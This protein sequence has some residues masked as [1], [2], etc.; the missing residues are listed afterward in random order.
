MINKPTLSNRNIPQPIQRQVRQ[1]CGFGCVFC[2][3]MIVQYEHIVPFSEVKAHEVANLVLLCA[4]HHQEVTAGRISKGQVKSAQITPFCKRGRN[5][6]SYRFILK[7]S[8]QIRFGDNSCVVT[9]NDRYP[10][11]IVELGEN[12]WFGVA[13]AEGLPVFSG[14]FP[15]KLGAPALVLRENV[16]EI[17]DTNIWDAT[18]KGPN[19][20]ISMGPRKIYSHWELKGGDFSILKQVMVGSSGAVKVS[21][22]GSEI[23]LSNGNISKVQH[24]YDFCEKY[25]RRSGFFASEGTVPRAAFRI[26]DTPPNYAVDHW[27]WVFT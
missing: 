13:M 1:N 27:R 10:L 2:G 12:C 20:K 18:L 14:T 8:H 16:L 9:E 19:L 6:P 7:H 21:H 15:N 24:N 22:K 4:S 5:H 25:N 3:D 23:L 17:L 26:P 11:S